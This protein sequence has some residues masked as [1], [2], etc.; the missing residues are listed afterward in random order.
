M[1][2]QDTRNG[3]ARK[4]QQTVVANEILQTIHIKRAIYLARSLIF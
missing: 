2:H 4:V 1:E 3:H